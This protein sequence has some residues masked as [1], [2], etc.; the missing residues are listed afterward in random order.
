VSEIR[1]RPT[2]LKKKK[3][4]I[5]GYSGVR[6]EQGKGMFTEYFEPFAIEKKNRRPNEV[7][8]GIMRGQ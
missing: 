6:E 8:V 2:W 7:M 1:T 5:D 3:K 4:W